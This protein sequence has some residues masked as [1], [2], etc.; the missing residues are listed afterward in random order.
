MQVLVTGGVAGDGL[1]EIGSG[2]FEHG[3][4]HFAEISRALF[5]D[6]PK[7]GKNLTAINSLVGGVNQFIL[8]QPPLLIRHARKE[9]QARLLTRRTLHRP[10]SQYFLKDI[11]V[12]GVAG[13]V[14]DLF[15]LPFG[16][17]AN[18]AR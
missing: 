14:A 3:Q 8:R 9:A 15:Q 1:V 6:R 17:F 5:V 12:A 13:G 4:R 18:F 10:S 16:V 11:P 2:R 7:R